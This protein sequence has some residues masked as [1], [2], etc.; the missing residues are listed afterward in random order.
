MTSPPQ[1]ES[2]LKSKGFFIL[3]FYMKLETRYKKQE[4]RGRS[5]CGAHFSPELLESLVSLFV[6]GLRPMWVYK[7]VWVSY[8][9]LSV[10]MVFGRNPIPC[11]RS[12]F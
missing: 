4:T 6:V 9:D 7:K 5:A 12:V 10:F 2:G 3:V 8:S 1:L 11:Q